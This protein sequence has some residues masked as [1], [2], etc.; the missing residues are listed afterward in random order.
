VDFPVRSNI[1]YAYA[2]QWLTMVSGHTAQDKIFAD[3]TFW[4]PKYRQAFESGKPFRSLDEHVGNP[5]AL[6]REWLSHPERD[7]YWD[8][9]NPS[10]GE[11]AKIAIPILT[12]TGSYDADQP[13]ALMH[14]RQHMKHA[15]P[16]ARAKHYLVMGPWDHGGCGLPQ[17][18]FCGL[19]MGPA[20]VIDM[21][22]LHCE[23]YAWTM[24]E[25]AKPEF[26]QKNVAYYVIGADKWRYADSLEA[27]T[28]REVPYYLSATENPT[29][30]FSSGS[31]DIE[32]PAVSEPDHY[33]YDPSDVSGA[34][35]ESTVDVHNLT[36]QQLVHA[37]HGRQLVYH[38]APFAADTEVSGFFKLSAWLAIDQPDTDFRATIY[39]VGLDGGTVLL[40]EDFLR[41]RYRESIRE[42]KLIEATEPLRYDFERFMF[43]SR[44]IKKG[45]RL[46]LVIGPLDSIHWQKNYNSGGV[47]SEESLKDARAVTVRLFHD[48][49]HPSALYVPYGQP[50][51]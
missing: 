42:P 43:T 20:S 27:V 16:E 33:V 9:H 23:W 49:A 26:L 2:I 38:S 34:E 19:K 8:R 50:E 13:G 4:W 41:A 11:S 7:E 37:R 48:E 39:E 30:V 3:R 6:Y 29:D 32:R 45:H 10:P 22:K 12:I 31:L 35:F 21:R 40:T 47:V 14:Y 51:T 28:A 46:R 25:G 15:S 17:A 24:Q 44:Q 18:E 1:V 5:N 36:N